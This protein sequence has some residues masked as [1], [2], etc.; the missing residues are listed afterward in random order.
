MNTGSPRLD[1]LVAR[2]VALG[3]TIDGTRAAPLLADGA[4]TLDDVAPFVEESPHTYTRRRVA[5]TEH[6]EML[7]MTWRP[8]Q[9]SG[10][11]DH[12]GSLCALRVLRGAASETRFAPAPD[13]LVEPRSAR[14]ILEGEVTVDRSDGVHA[15][16]NDPS[17]SELLVTLH[18]YAP[19]LPELR[20]FALRRSREALAPAFAR[21]RRRDA[22]LVAIVGGGFSGTLTAAHLVR[23]AT[24]AQRPLHVTLCDRQAAFGEG[25]AYRTADPRHLLNV[26]AARMSAWPDRPGD[27]VRWAQARDPSIA[28]S[29]FLPRKIYGEYVREALLATAAEAGDGVSLE[30]R[31]TE[32]GAIEEA[33]DGWRVQAGGELDAAAVVL[34]VGHRPPDDPLRDRWTGKRT[35]Y[36]EDPWASLALSAIRPDEPVV[37]LGTGLTAIDVL[38]SVAR[39]PR[40]AP[41]IA[42][43]RRGLVPESHAPSGRIDPSAW[44]EPLL[45]AERGLRARDLAHA[46]LHEIRVAEREG[47]DFRSIVDGL[48]PHTPRIWAALS[49]RERQRFIRHLRPFWEVVRHRTAPSIAA[50]VAQLRERGILRVLAGRVLSAEG[51][52]EGA[53]LEARP[54]GGRSPIELRASWVVNCTGPGALTRLPLPLATLA[55]HDHV[56]VDPLGLGL[57]TDEHGWAVGAHGPR[58]DLVV[59]GTLRK[60]Q[61]WESTAVPELREQ[62]RSAARL[63]L[64]AL[65]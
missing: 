27:F 60:P 23:L 43:S 31:R 25:P 59:V 24:E 33:P 35:R 12:A 52:D 28:P 16:V 6:F 48:R 37:L 18:V 56:R 57:L 7:V 46:L 2:L 30:V 65:S 21:A 1:E 29:D 36:I 14:P 13:G 9:G 4:L 19:P 62:A 50:Q 53:T 39:P 51:D 45:A 22:P 55:A 5:R 54:R 32:V 41:V 17:A 61:L 11:H 38:L 40:S 15:L 10:P 47:G 44:L 8:G 42:I 3:P 26:P 49:V 58:P 64:Q 63:V 34:A 20:R